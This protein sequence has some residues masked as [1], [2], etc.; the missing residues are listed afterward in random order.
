MIVAPEGTPPAR[1]PHRV[2][3]FIIHT[4]FGSGS[5]SAASATECPASRPCA[6]TDLTRSMGG[7]VNLPHGGDREDHH[8]ETPWW[9]QM[10]LSHF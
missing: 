10:A 2:G 1:W 9:L 6:D 8:R 5:R 4:H 7:V 3:G